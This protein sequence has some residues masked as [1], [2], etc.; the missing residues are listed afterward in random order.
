MVVSGGDGCKMSFTMLLAL[1]E[2]GVQY[3]R[4]LDEQYER[5]G[6][7]EEVVLECHRICLSTDSGRVRTVATE[8]AKMVDKLK[9]LRDTASGPFA[10]LQLMLPW[11]TRPGG[12]FQDGGVMAPLTRYVSL[13][14]RDLVRWMGTMSPGELEVLA[15]PFG[16]P[17]EV[18]IAW[19]EALGW[20]LI[21]A[22]TAG[23][24]CEFFFR[25]ESRRDPR[26]DIPPA[27][28]EGG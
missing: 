8:G 13:F 18:Y 16:G 9:A 28:T 4:A 26:P 12:V 7:P 17:I 6:A 25:G 3:M 19:A 20:R 24:K 22:N 21:T 15:P 2:A 23:P 5:G 1:L 27:R 10:T 14:Y 11:R